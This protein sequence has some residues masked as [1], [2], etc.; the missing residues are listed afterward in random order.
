MARTIVVAVDASEH[1]KFAVEWAVSNL[2][3]A[4]DAVVLL[5]VQDKPDLAHGAFSTGD[6]AHSQATQWLDL[7]VFGLSFA[8]IPL[9]L[10]SLHLL[11]F[12]PPLS[13]SIPLILRRFTNFF[14]SARVRLV[15]CSSPSS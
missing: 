1:S 5:H 15:S 6:G 12:S 3:K 11:F 13:S 2:F 14:L 4:D 10:S 7:T 9:I 8:L